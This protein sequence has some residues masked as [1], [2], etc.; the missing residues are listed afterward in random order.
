MLYGGSRNRFTVDERVIFERLWR[1]AL[2]E[3]LGTKATFRARSHCCC[4]CQC[5]RTTAN[6]MASNNSAVVPCTPRKNTMRSVVRF[7]FMIITAKLGFMEEIVGPL[8]TL[9]LVIR[10]VPIQRACY[11]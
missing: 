10:V 11:L 3:A 7:V 5:M 1:G 2:C 8:A 6:I 4:H 9:F